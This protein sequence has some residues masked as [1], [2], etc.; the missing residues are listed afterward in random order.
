MR[1]TGGRTHAPTSNGLAPRRRVPSVL[2]S[3]EG[4]RHGAPQ[5]ENAMKKHGL[6]GLFLALCAGLML[7]TP[8]TGLHARPKKSKK[9]KSEVSRDAPAPLAKAPK[10]KP[11]GLKWKLKPKQVA[12]I[13]DSAIERDYL[14]RYKD[15]E[16]GI[17]EERL[18]EEIRTRKRVF[19]QSYMQLDHPPG[20][21]DGGPFVGEYGYYNKEGYM[22][23]K[24]KGRWRYL[25]FWKSKLYKIIDVHRLR[26]DGKWGASFDKAVAKVEAALGAEGRKL[27]PD[28]D[29]G[30]RRA[31][32]DWAD[33]KT[34]FR[35]VRWTKKKVAFVW[36]NKKIEGP[37]VAARAKAKAKK[38]KDMDP[39]VKDV[40]RKK[41]KEKPRGKKK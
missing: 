30:R 28:A 6:W 29:E 39:K 38:K 15:V 16:P 17:Q 26:K 7:V 20:A 4:T 3:H 24:R 11:R 2:S 9:E 23:I 35:V 12:D 32:V 37:I 1:Q 40:L 18:K 31:E 14:K 36:V 21:L 41:K 22:K 8:T 34:H 5:W 13:Y 25:F 19:R 10:L 27:A 33:S